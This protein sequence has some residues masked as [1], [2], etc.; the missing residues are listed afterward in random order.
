[1]PIYRNVYDHSLIT[2]LMSITERPW[3]REGEG[4]REGGEVRGRGGGEGRR[5]SEDG[6]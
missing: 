1:M 6:R 2:N 4:R 3:G 5:G